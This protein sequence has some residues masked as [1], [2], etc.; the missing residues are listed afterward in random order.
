MKKVKLESPYIGIETVDGFALLYNQYGEYSVIMKVENPI[1]QFS[2][3]VDEYYS[4]HFTYTSIIKMLGTGFI[5][6]KQ[7]ILSKRKFAKNAVN[8]SFLTKKFFEHFTGRDYVDIS[9]Y[10]IITSVMNRG[11]FFNFDKNKYNLFKTS[12]VKILDFLKNRGYNVTLLREK[13]IKSYIYHYFGFSFSDS[14]FRLSN[15]QSGHNFLKIDNREVKVVSLVDVEMV[16]VPTT[17]YPYKTLRIGNSE[18]PVDL[19]NFFFKIPDTDNVVFNQVI[20]IPE[21]RKTLNNLEAKKRKHI[22]MPDPD[23][24]LAVSDIESVMAEVARTGQIFVNTHFDIIISGNNI[25]KSFNF[26]ES[27]F[28]DLNFIVSKQAYNQFEL[29]I[30]SMPGNANLLKNYDWFLCTSDAAVCLLYKERRQTDENSTFLMNFT[31]RDGVPIAIDPCDLPILTGRCTNRNKFVLGPSGSGKSFFTNHMVRWYVEE[32]ADVVIV[33]TGHSYAGTCEYYGGKYITYSEEKP[34]TMNPFLVKKEEYNEEKRQFIKSLIAVLWKGTE[35]KLTQSEDTLLG[36]LIVFY[37]DSYF[38]NNKVPIEE[39][40]ISASLAAGI[41][42]N[43]FENFL[44]EIYAQKPEELDTLYKK[45]EN[46]ANIKTSEEELVNRFVNFLVLRSKINSDYKVE[47]LSFNSFYEYA[48]KQI[49]VIIDSTKEV[50]GKPI[51]FD[52]TGFAFVLK[53]FY[54]GG[55]FDRTLNDEGDKSL[56]SEQFI[57]FEIDAIKDHAKLFPIVTLIIMDVFL[58]KMRLKRNRKVLIIEEAWKAIAS[59]LMAGYIQ[60]L[61]KT[62]RKFLGEAIV[63][64]QELDDIIGNPIVKTAI[65]ANSDCIMLLDQQKFKDKYQDIAN[66]LSLSQIE[67]NK[68]FTI[69]QLDNKNGRNSFKEVYIRRGNT[70]EV[71]GVEVSL[72]EYLIYTTERREKDTLALFKSVYKNFD[73]AVEKF[74]SALKRAEVN[75]VEFTSLLISDIFIKYYLKK[76]LKDCNINEFEQA[77]ET[78]IGEYKNSGYSLLDFIKT[79]GK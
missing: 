17:I 71:Y 41:L 14:N 43:E 55:Q 30:A 13:Q 54:K 26:V 56:F 62:V 16:D 51:R 67:Q 77:V 63:V 21:Q 64:T 34:I 25:E 58:Q 9:S 12:V 45:Y 19:L 47:S 10:L 2:A 65:I 39:K 31:D 49:P 75:M 68:I 38:G 3:D 48:N 27:S 61:W 5:L 32:G 42:D 24:N 22:S 78:T 57:V 46:I 53:Q 7:D 40:E 37:Y 72:Y 35:G 66:I 76:K 79:K 15:F 33:D 60:Y 4:F 6:Q 50:S 20:E 28:F 73:T 59:P 36:D 69:N 29:F 74:I 44:L 18:F 70:G 23:N 8:Q 1:V 52:H 11:K